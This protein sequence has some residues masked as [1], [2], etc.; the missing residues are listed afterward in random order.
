MQNA[1]GAILG[2]FDCWLAMRGLKT[3]AL[4][5]R[6]PAAWQASLR[7]GWQFIPWSGRSTTQVSPRTRATVY[8][9]RRHLLEVPCCPL[10]TGRC[11]L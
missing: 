5:M 10:E 8:T 3:M 4:R 1:E 2:P 11:V 7:A 6:R 9:L